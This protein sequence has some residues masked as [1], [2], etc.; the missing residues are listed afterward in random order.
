M[1]DIANTRIQYARGALRRADLAADPI[2]QFQ[3]WLTAATHAGILEPNA[4][5]LATITADGMPNARVVL[6]KG[7]DAAGFR[8]FTN[9][10]S[11]KGDE[12]AANPVATLVFYWDVL[13][14]Q[15]R[16]HGQVERLSATESA[17]YFQ[18]RPRDSQIGAWASPQSASIADRSTLRRAVEAAAERFATSEQIPRPPHWGGYV[19]KPSWIE[20]WQGRMNRLHDRFRYR[21]LANAAWR[22]ERLA[23]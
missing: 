12:L 7:V 19:V 8:F 2:E 6:L 18:V 10:Q 15:V 3:R 5:T 22:I 16:V 14:R 20:F 1:N 11:Q 21:R 17:A 13:H 9:Y 23:P 4:M